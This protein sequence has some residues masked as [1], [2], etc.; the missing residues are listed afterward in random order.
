MPIVDYFSADGKVE[1]AWQGIFVRKSSLQ[2]PRPFHCK[3]YEITA[4]NSLVVGEELE[5]V[6]WFL[7]QLLFRLGPCWLKENFSSS[8]RRKKN[9]FVSPFVNRHF[10]TSSCVLWRER[11]NFKFKKKRWSK[12]SAS[13]NLWLWRGSNLW[14]EI[15]W[16]PLPFIRAVMAHW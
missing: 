1:E 12:V 3:T 11:Q 7:S 9:I 4:C 2:F 5:K 10:Y 16:C 14:L 13:Q 6:R 15:G 8:V